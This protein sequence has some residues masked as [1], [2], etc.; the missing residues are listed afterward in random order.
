[1]RENCPNIIHQFD[2]WHFSKKIKKGLLAKGKQ[3]RNENLAGWIKTII[4]HF[5][6][7]SATCQG[8]AVLIRGKWLSILHHVS[9]KHE[10]WDGHELYQAC[11]HGPL[12]PEEERLKKLLPEGSP[13]HNAL[14]DVITGTNILK[15]LSHLT[16][17]CHSGELEV[18]HS[19]YNMYCPKRIAFSYPGMHVRTQLAVMD[20]NSG[21]SRVDKGAKLLESCIL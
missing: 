12:S 21:I 15:D 10:E 17:F 18:Y 3:K 2:L 8:N 6:W 1:M 13:A 7:C 16:L 5:C 14:K 19:L 4:N 20:H 11:E 9:N